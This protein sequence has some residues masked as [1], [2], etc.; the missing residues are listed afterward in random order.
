MASDLLAMLEAEPR[1][2]SLPSSPNNTLQR[3]ISFS[4]P[5]IE[6]LSNLISPIAETACVPSSTF[7]LFS[8]PCELNVSNLLC[9]LADV[10]SQKRKYF[11]SED[12][13]AKKP[14]LDV[15]KITNLL[16]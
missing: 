10:A 13:S 11:S 1:T 8:V 15:M 9:D 5:K 3:N 7:E 4:C 14:R 16:V 2:D 6:M 12:Y